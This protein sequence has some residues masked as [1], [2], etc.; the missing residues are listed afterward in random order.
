MQM[1]ELGESGLQVSAVG[2]GCWAIGGS[3]GAV[4]DDDSLR[5]LHRAVDQGVRFFDTADVYGDGRSERL[6]G[7]LL[8]ERTEPLVVATKAGRRAQPHTVE[9]Y[10]VQSLAAYVDRSLGNLGVDRIDLLQL[11]CPPAEV[12]DRPEVFA[13]L[14]D[15]V[16]AGKLARYGVSI[17]RIA[18]GLKAIEYP[19]VASLQVIY[20]LLR[21]RPGDVLLAAA[22]ARG[23]G[24]IARVPL[25]S[26]LLT[27][28]FDAGS[29]FEADDHR[30]FN[31]EGEAFDSGETFSGVPF[32][33][34][35][36]LVEE[37]RGI[38]PAQPSM[39]AWALRWILMRPE[40]STV[41]PGAK[42]PAHIDANVAASALDPLD[43]STMARLRE[44]YA[45]KVAPLVH[46]RW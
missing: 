35:L 2:M 13:G 6:V 3:W 18:D 14:D 27:G 22:R 10:S 23:V 39:A 21:Q 33:A 9:A 44:L 5:T 16:A 17:E 40:V 28:K 15:L 12:F 34:G 11:H 31:R 19:G 36:E 30:R 42:T 8:A 29:R 24:I 38:L 41:I 26:G 37:L 1:R 43:A 46:H 20:N 45:R 25:A 32:D 7:R 4:V